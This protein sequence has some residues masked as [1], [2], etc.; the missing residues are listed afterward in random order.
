[1]PNPT[2]QSY[3]KVD[4]AATPGPWQWVPPAQAEA[5]LDALDQRRP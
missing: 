1:V 5:D 3:L 2:R 4:L